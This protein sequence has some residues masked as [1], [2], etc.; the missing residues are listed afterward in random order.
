MD[1]EIKADT[2]K[3]EDMIYL[4]FIWDLSGIK[5][6]KMYFHSESFFWFYSLNKLAS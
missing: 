3:L 4:N 5:K 2:E 1:M 6:T